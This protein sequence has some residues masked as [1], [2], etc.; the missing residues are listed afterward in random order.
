MSSAKHTWDNFLGDDLLEKTW[1]ARIGY[2]L[3]RH[4]H[5]ANFMH[6]CVPSS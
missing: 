4:G 1:N 5:K 6:T 3:F 2:T